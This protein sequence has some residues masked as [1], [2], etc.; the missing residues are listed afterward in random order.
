MFTSTMSKG[1]FYFISKRMKKSG[2]TLIE[3]LIVVVII[4]ILASALLPRLQGYMAKTRDLKRQADLRN[5]AAAI[6]MY[7]ND[8]GEFPKRNKIRYVAPYVGSASD[9]TGLTEYLA[10]IPKDPN[11]KQMIK[12]HAWPLFGPSEP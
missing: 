4:G 6:Q 8:Y 10:E 3:M 7:R 9:L 11:K 12:I 2:F 5:I 1:A